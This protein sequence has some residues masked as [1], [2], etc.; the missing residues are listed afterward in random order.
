ME[1]LEKYQAA[2]DGYLEQVT[3]LKKRL[4]SGDE[5]H[6]FSSMKRTGEVEVE[7]YVV[8]EDGKLKVTAG[9]HGPPAAVFHETYRAAVPQIVEDTIKTLES[10][11]MDKAKALKKQLADEQ[12]EL[13]KST[14]EIEA[15]IKKPAPK[16]RTPKPPPTPAPSDGRDRA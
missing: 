11:V 5:V 15:F 13:A 9:L 7:A 6:V 4:E 3:L 12:K 1:E 10:S 16:K 14:K 8:G 2:L